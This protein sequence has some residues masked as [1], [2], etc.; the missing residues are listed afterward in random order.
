MIV[1]IAIKLAWLFIKGANVILE[2]YKFAIYMKPRIPLF[3]VY[4]LMVEL[5]TVL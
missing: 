5:G 3:C 1:F 2:W 4:S